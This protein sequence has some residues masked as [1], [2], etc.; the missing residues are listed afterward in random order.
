ML[1]Q[2]SP[3][4]S[5]EGRALATIVL[6]NIPS[7]FGSD[8]LKSRLVDILANYFKTKDV[9]IYKPKNNLPFCPG[10][11]NFNAVQALKAENT[12]G[13]ITDLVVEELDLKLEI[14]FSKPGGKTT[15]FSPLKDHPSSKAS[16]AN[17]IPEYT[18]G[19]RRSRTVSEP[20]IKS[21][22]SHLHGTKQGRFFPYAIFIND[23]P[24]EFANDER[25]HMI[26]QAHFKDGVL[27]SN[28]PRHKTQKYVTMFINYEEKEKYLKQSEPFGES[29]ILEIREDWLSCDLRVERR[30]KP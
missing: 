11:V 28:K 22:Q 12:W 30:R 6:K 14:S 20:N 16:T 5:S 25:V 29:G 8:P 3:R 21:P 23:I 9:V 4:R 17:S 26:L 24:S 2:R 1:G 7:K 18:E 15:T 13:S 27:E 10:F 19:V